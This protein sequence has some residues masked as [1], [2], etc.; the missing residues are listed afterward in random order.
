MIFS[1]VSPKKLDVDFFDVCAAAQTLRALP[2][3]WGILLA[4]ESA[5][6]AA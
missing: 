5:T 2:V 4:L 1:T 6:G 3:D